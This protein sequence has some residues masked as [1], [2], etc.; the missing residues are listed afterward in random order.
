MSEKLCFWLPVLLREVVNVVRVRCCQQSKA[1]PVMVNAMLL[2]AFRRV[3]MTI[4]V[5]T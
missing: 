1:M 4:A 3:W 5:A 2:V